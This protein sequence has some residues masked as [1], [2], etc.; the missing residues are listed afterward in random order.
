MPI[1]DSTDTPTRLLGEI[2]PDWRVPVLS[3]QNY[4]TKVAR[5]KN[6]REQRV[7]FRPSARRVQ[8]Y[9]L[10]SARIAAG[11]DQVAEH[12]DRMAGPLEVPWWAEGLRLSVTMATVNDAQL[13]SEPGTDQGFEAGDSILVGDAVRTIA[14]RATKFL[15][16]DSMGGSVQETT[17]TWCY[18]LRVC[19]SRDTGALQNIRH[20][21]SDVRLR[22]EEI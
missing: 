10:S 5:T 3:F 15:T 2:A 6:G 12:A 11:E 16:L 8:T 14:S 1:P 18:P 4:A 17:G 13:E 7:S 21:K 20:D 19:I 22:F 9:T